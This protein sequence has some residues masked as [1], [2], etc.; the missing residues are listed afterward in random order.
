MR[1]SAHPKTVPDDLAWYA[2]LG[3][4]YHYCPEYS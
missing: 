3:A 4:E 1:A 2:V